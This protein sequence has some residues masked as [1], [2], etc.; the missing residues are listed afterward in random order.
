MP[1]QDIHPVDLHVGEQIRAWRKRRE[2]TQ[3]QLARSVGL[4]FQQVQK[5]ETGLNR[6]SASMLVDLARSLE[7]PVWAFFEGLPEVGGLDGDLARRA[8]LILSSQA[9]SRLLG[10]L[11]SL[12]LSAQLRIIDSLRELSFELRAAIG[13]TL[14]DPLDRRS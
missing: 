9:S 10:L 11:A 14:L 12:P 6:V 4:T 2:L 5:Y 1:N 7:A 3:A 8:S 13:S